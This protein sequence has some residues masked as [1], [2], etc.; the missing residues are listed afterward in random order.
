MKI[1]KDY[2]LARNGGE[3]PIWWSLQGEA[4]LRGFQMAFIRLAGCDVNCEGCDTDY[5]MGE[6]LSVEEIALQIQTITPIT[7]RDKWVWITGGEPTIHNLR[8]LLSMLSSLRYSTAIATAGHRRMIPPVDWLSVSPHNPSKWIQTYGNEVKI[9]PG[10]NGFDIDD[11][12]RVHPDSQTDFMY[13]YVQ[14][15]WDM[16]KDCEDRESLRCCFQFLK[17]NPNWSLSRQDHKLWG[18]R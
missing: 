12:L 13:R 9:V 5:T 17:G 18:A 4:H 16:E 14:P 15:L 3:S 2:P 1:L 7:C 11:F 8:P 10:L 6:R